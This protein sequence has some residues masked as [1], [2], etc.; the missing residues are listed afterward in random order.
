VP[1]SKRSPILRPLLKLPGQKLDEDLQD[2]LEDHLLA[3]IMVLIMIAAMC[4][5]E[6]AGYL[7]NSPRNPWIYTWWLLGAAVVIA[8]HWRRQWREAARLK[9]GR[10]GERAVAEYLN[11]RLDADSR[12]LHGVPLEGATADHVLICTRGVFVIETK[13]RSLPRRGDPVVHVVDTGVR[14]NGFKSDRDPIVQTL[15]YVDTLNR[16]LPE[17]VTPKIKAIGIVVFPSYKVVDD[18]KG[19][20]CIWVLEPK[21]LAG[22]LD[23]EPKQLS[24]DDVVLLT[25]RLASYIRPPS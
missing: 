19:D 6:W 4:L 8:I 22:R 17:L 7:K 16:L 20:R 12:V 3:P 18:R 5:V 25:R 1:L 9:L 2:F 10:E 24:A 13:A 14:V 23:K 11:I 15:R 21:E